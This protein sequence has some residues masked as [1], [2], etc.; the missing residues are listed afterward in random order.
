MLAVWFDTS[1][2]DFGNGTAAGDVDLNVD[3]AVFAARGVVG[4][5]KQ[6]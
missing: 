1:A 5:S 4:R 3:D 2:V 6:K